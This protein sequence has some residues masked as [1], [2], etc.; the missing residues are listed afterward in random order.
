MHARW[1][2]FNR[3]CDAIS[4][5]QKRLQ[6]TI[7]RPDTDAGNQIAA[8][9]E[10]PLAREYRL[11]ELLRRPNLSY[12]DLMAIAE[13]GPGIDDVKAAE[14]IEI[15]AKYAGYIDRQEDEIARSL[16][17]E[18]LKLP[19]KLNYAEIPG[20][21]AEV[22]QKLNQTRPATIGMASRIPGMTPAAISLLLVHLKRRAG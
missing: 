17:Q 10:Q 22:Q 20:L 7:V 13:L 9:L 4:T 11:M 12:Q 5:E 15:Q 16:R 6:A 18:T 14:Q 1:E 2:Y 21:S 19:E 3:K 8:R